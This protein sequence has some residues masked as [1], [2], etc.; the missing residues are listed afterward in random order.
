M[1]PLLP[2]V[3][4]RDFRSPPPP[5]P[6]LQYNPYEGV[7]VEGTTSQDR[8]VESRGRGRENKFPGMFGG[9]ISISPRGPEASNAQCK[10]LSLQQKPLV[11]LYCNFTSLAFLGL[12][13]FLRSQLKILIFSY[14]PKCSQEASLLSASLGS[15]TSVFE[16][17]SKH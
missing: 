6:P 7:L 5:P 15:G 13:G 9:W 1:L 10:T 4:T 16:P 3:L 17:S 8:S 12:L 2:T 14:P 11:V